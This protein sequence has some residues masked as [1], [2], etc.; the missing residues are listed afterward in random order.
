MDFFR[1]V[2]DQR[3]LRKGQLRAWNL[4]PATVFNEGK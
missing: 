2:R 1:R 4:S 3:G